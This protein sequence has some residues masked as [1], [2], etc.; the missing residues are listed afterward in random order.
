MFLVYLI[1]LIV[2]N[3][4]QLFILFIKFIIIFYIKFI[5]IIFLFHFYL[6]HFI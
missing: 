2:V 1:L 6:I 4:G 3:Y 5:I